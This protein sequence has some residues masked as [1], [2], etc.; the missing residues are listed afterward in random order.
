MLEAGVGL[1]PRRGE[2]V[3]ELRG[4]RALPGLINAH[5]HLGLNLLPHLGEPPYDSLYHFAEDVYRPEQSPIRDTLRAAALDRLLWGGFKNLISGVTT[6]IHHD[7]FPRRVLLHPAYPVTIFRRYAWSHSL[8]FGDDPAAAYARRRGRPFIIHAA[9]GVDDESYGEIGRLDELGLLGPDTVL[10]HAI[11]STVADCERLA[12]A[13]TSVVWCPASNL[14]LYHRT[15]PLALLRGRIRLALGTDSTLTGSAT[16]LGELQIALE[17]GLASAEEI[18]EM[19]TTGAAAIFRLS[20]ERGRIIE[21][22]VA[23][24]MVVPDTGAGAAGDLLASHP[25]HLGLVTCGGRP[26]LA[27]A[28]WAEALDLGSPNARVEGV[29]RWLCGDPRGLRR[30]IGSAVG[31]SVLGANPLWSL[32]R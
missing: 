14:R 28:E 17:T 3:L 7:P 30:R 29:P 6:V 1:A 21:G 32:L 27:T 18:L 12:A 16:L 11:A 9:E 26:R 5:D 31:E 22:A 2:K 23:D 19:V 15:A 8:R 24:L 13:R 25:A 20:G 4:W 10:I